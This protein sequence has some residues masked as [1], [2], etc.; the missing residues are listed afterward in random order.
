MKQL[1]APYHGSETRGFI[2]RTFGGAIF[3]AF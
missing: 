2:L 1:V 3:P